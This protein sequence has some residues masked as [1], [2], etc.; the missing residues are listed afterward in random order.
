MFYLSDW[1]GI[2]FQIEAEECVIG[3]GDYGK[4]LTMLVAIDSVDPEEL[5]EEQ[6]MIESWHPKFHR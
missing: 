4:T 1:L 5:A 3:L 6:D 2:S